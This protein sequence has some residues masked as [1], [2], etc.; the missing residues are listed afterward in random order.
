[1]FKKNKNM[2]YNN[3]NFL[4]VFNKEKNQQKNL[5]YTKSFYYITL[6]YI[7]HSILYF[8]YLFVCVY[9]KKILSVTIQQNN[10]KND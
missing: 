3:I 9:K 2:F 10:T 7:T 6:C 5:I 4:T 8:L 1:M